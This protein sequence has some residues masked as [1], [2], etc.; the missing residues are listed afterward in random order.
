MILTRVLDVIV[1]VM[2]T[3]GCATLTP[4]GERIRV[5]RNALVV[6]DCASLGE[7]TATSGWGGLLAE[8]AGLESNARALRTRTAE[9]GGDTVL[10]LAERGTFMPNTIGEAYRCAP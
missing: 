5:V 1:I 8:R 6:R 4:E 2:V 10:I 3:T 9:R 7:I